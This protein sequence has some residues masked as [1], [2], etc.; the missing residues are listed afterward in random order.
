MPTLNRLPVGGATGLNVF[1]Q[2][3]EPDVKKGIWIK[4]N[5]ECKRVVN[6]RTVNSTLIITNPLNPLY[7][8][9]YINGKIHI[10]TRDNGTVHKYPT[11]VS[12]TESDQHDTSSTII[13]TYEG[14]N[15]SYDIYINSSYGI[16][17][18]DNALMN[19]NNSLYIAAADDNGHCTTYSRTI[20]PDTKFKDKISAAVSTMY[21]FKDSWGCVRIEYLFEEYTFKCSN[22]LLIDYSV[23]AQYY[24]R[25]DNKNL[26][27]RYNAVT[28]AT[29]ISDIPYGRIACACSGKLFDN[30][31]LTYYT[32]F[33]GNKL[34]QYNPYNNTHT[35]ICNTLPTP[36][37]YSAM[38]VA[39]NLY[40]INNDSDLYKFNKSGSYS[41]V[42][43][44][45]PLYGNKY[46]TKSDDDIY[47]YTCK[48]KSI[49]EMG[50]YNYHVVGQVYKS[51]IN[52]GVSTLMVNISDSGKNTDIYS[53]DNLNLNVT[54]DGAFYFD[55][56][57]NSGY[58]TYYGNGSQWI[59][60]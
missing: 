15:G 27:V 17:N 7:G 47:V 48:N 30:T 32:V 53:S 12:I 13:E 59:Q 8:I 51:N 39:R 11:L 19:V 57:G 54:F 36:T 52:T 41:L 38:I 37:I 28:G 25:L 10:L 50:G 56:N 23:G 60:L 34:C 46:V 35:I 44:N 1:T 40:V 29:D 2:L 18:Y 21:G 45:F 43:P 9:T 3:D 26:L 20:N 49:P 16:S 58:P 6:M 42:Q 5:Q 55:G 22:Y 4:T 31:E 14:D 24:D 33:N